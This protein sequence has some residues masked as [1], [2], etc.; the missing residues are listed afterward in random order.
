MIT[1]LA[2]VARQL[3]WAVDIIGAPSTLLLALLA[4]AGEPVHYA[5][6]RVV[7][8]MSAA[9]TGEGKSDIKDA[10]HRADLI[11]N[12]V[13]TLSRWFGAHSRAA[14]EDGRALARELQR[15]LRRTG[16]PTPRLERLLTTL[17]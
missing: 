4:Q 2:R 10:Y 12:R 16:R 6:G 9:I 14:P 17:P 7:A 1:N 15:A 11:A 5:S 13:R 8:A 3:A